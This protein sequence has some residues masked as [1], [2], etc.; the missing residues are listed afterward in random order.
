LEDKEIIAQWYYASVKVSEKLACD[1]G[2]LQIPHSAVAPQAFR[3][4]TK[5]GRLA[6]K[7][8]LCH[9]FGVKMIT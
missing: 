8:P 9:P 4:I 3:S 7:T 6:V 1:K 2:Y 5:L